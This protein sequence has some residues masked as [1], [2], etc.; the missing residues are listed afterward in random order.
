MSLYESITDDITI[1]YCPFQNAIDFN[2][3]KE[4]KTTV[5]ICRIYT[6]ANL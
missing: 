6:V 2:V 1:L 5:M 3:R 4:E